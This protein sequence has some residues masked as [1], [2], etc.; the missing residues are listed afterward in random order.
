MRAPI[1][2]LTPLVPLRSHAGTLMRATTSPA[3]K[4]PIEGYDLNHHYLTGS[5]AGLLAALRKTVEAGAGGEVPPPAANFLAFVGAAA[6]RAPEIAAG[7]R[8][9][10]DDAGPA[11]HAFVDA[12]LRAAERPPPR[13]PART[14]EDLDARWSEFFATGEPAPLR[15]I[16]AVLA[17]KDW[18][19]E[20]VEGLLR[21]RTWT[22]LLF[23]ARR[24]AQL[25][26]RLGALDV[27]V[28]VERATVRNATDLDGAILRPDLSVDGERVATLQQALP[29][30]LTAPELM[31]IA[32][33]TSA[34]WSLASNAAAHPMVVDAC[35]EA[36]AGAD[37]RVRLSLQ[38]VVAHARL[39]H[40]EFAAALALA[41]EA[42]AVE[43]GDAR[44]LETRRLA[45]EGL[46]REA[47]WA[48]L[49]ATSDAAVGAAIDTA[50]LRA[51]AQEHAPEAYRVLAVVRSPDGVGDPS[52]GGV[53]G[54]HDL[55]FRGDRVRGGRWF[56]DP[57]SAQGLADEW[58]TLPTAHFENPG[59]W[60]CLPDRVRDPNHRALRRE[61]YVALAARAPDAVERRPRP[62]GAYL[63]LR[64]DGAELPGLPAVIKPPDGALAVTLWLR[65]SD[66]ALVGAE[67]RSAGGDRAAPAL[68]RMVFLYD[69]G[70]PEIEAPSSF[71]DARNGAPTRPDA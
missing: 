49:D 62:D 58:I 59:L 11:G 61:S 71:V 63:G 32:V 21:E 56:W 1:G 26:E 34:L 22:D 37:A 5:P 55:V 69:E 47:A 19:R 48:L 38:A 42:L 39:A 30:P 27:R 18:L 70:L 60:V 8:A 33:K 53:A 67:V 17:W 13:G 23:G 16:V 41:D 25:I 15:E 68:V 46:A 52:R 45:R 6:R 44:S 57:T 36:L 14:A 40:G 29:R 54:E 24:R 64:Y 9:L 66:G 10:R 65:E 7:L 12:F 31:T 2:R 43:P 4:S 50:P 51:R 3:P 20:H 35:L 28:D